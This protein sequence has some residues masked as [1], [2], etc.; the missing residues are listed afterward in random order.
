MDTE[1]TIAREI[2]E[3]FRTGNKALLF[4]NGGSAADAQHIACELITKGHPAIALTTDSSVL[5]A[6]AND[7]GFE[8][9]FSRQ[10]RALVKPGDIAIGIST[11]GNS[12]NVIAGIRE[13][14]R[15]GAMTVAFTG[16]GGKLSADFTLAIPSN[17]THRIQE[18]HIT[19]GHSICD[20][21]EE[22]NAT[23]HMD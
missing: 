12:P 21:V 19:A 20:L 22:M 6:I 3:A 4:G 17:N 16:Q 23:S 18:A 8:E 14:K 15:H 5:T 7:Y 13:A 10:L 1:T 11:S 9:V 2:A